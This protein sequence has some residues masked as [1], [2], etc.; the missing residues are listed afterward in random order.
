MPLVNTEVL[1][2]QASK[3]CF[4]CGMYSLYFILI[5]EGPKNTL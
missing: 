5:I 2:L 3:L 4:I 1:L